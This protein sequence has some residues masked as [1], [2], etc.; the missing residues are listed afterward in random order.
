MLYGHIASVN[1]IIFSIHGKK[2]IL[3]IMNENIVFF[4]IKKWSGA[5]RS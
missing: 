5:A 1:G 2:E 3:K 4:N